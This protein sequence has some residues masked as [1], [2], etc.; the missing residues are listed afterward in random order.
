MLNTDF[1]FFDIHLSKFINKKNNILEINADK[2]YTTE[3]FLTYLCDDKDSIIISIDTWN[4]SKKYK[5]LNIT[6]NEKIFDKN[7]NKTGKSNQVIK[8][9]MENERAIQIIR[10]NKKT[11]NIFNIVYIDCSYFDEKLILNCIIGL[12]LLEDGGIMI[13]DDCNWDDMNK[14]FFK[15]NIMIKSFIYRYKSKIKILNKK[16]QIIIQKKNININIKNKEYY[17]LIDSIEKYKLCD[18]WHV[19]DNT[20]KI[21]D[22]NLILSN[23]PSEYKSKFGA[24]NEYQKI[25]N[26]YYTPESIGYK[27][28]GEYQLN[29]FLRMNADLNSIYNKFSKDI[30]KEIIIYNYNPFEAIKKMELV[31]GNLTEIDMYDIVSTLINKKILNIKNINSL[32]VMNFS[33]WDVNTNGILTDYLKKLLNIKDIIT[34]SI[35]NS[36]F[37][38]T[39][40]KDLVNK[41]N[42]KQDV[43]MISLFTKKLFLKEKY[44][45]EKYYIL[46]ILYCIIFILSIGKI[47]SCGVFYTFSIFTDISIELL[48]ILKKYYKNII[49][50][51]HML[52]NMGNRLINIIACDF[53]GIE[54]YE[55]KKLYDIAEEIQLYDKHHDDYDELDYKYISK[56]LNIDK[57]QKEYIIFEKKITDFNLEFIELVIKNR[58]IIDNIIYFLNNKNMSKNI[59]NK[60]KKKIIEKQIT[61]LFSWINT[62]LIYND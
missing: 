24:N 58:D 46:Q 48:W 34:Q 51:C 11:N 45:S 15:S 60:L 13:L 3:W 55:L 61:N 50:N 43:I 52:T 23:K 1:N 14:D 44:Y 35:K 37:N 17:N 10:N 40:L 5:D 26:T 49:L 27:N 16:Y 8:M 33:Y 53:I 28:F 22:Y 7:I 12:D 19:L 42:I 2:G 36:I 38:I 57:T 39:E 21:L 20:V 9:K 31:V 59:K 25:I 41:I 29:K 47:N 18:I 4:K 56:I 6:I 62:H 32:Y 54:E 30:D